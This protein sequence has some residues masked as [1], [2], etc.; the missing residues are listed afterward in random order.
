MWCKKLHYDY[1]D[2][3]S[4]QEARLLTAIDRRLLITPDVEKA[5]TKKEKMYTLEQAKRIVY[6]YLNE[7]PKYDYPDE[8]NY[9][10]VI[11][12]IQEKPYGWV[13]SYQ[14]KDYLETEDYRTAVIGNVPILFEKATGKLIPLGV[15][16]LES[17]KLYEKGDLEY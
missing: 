7:P 15:S 13:F 6:E 17:L 4:N 11:S 10:I 8:P 3:A 9:E 12:H 14:S 5:G 2:I 16:P 1:K